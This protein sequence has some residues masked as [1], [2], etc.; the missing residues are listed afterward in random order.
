MNDEDHHQYLDDFCSTF[1]QAVVRLIDQAGEEKVEFNYQGS[2]AEMK[3]I[4]D[5]YIETLEH[6]HQCQ[7]K[8][9]RFYGR[10]DILNCIENYI[11]SDS[12]QPYVVHGE[13]GCGKT[14]V[15][16][17]AAMLVSCMYILTA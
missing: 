4:T 3:L 12:R 16:A 6:A 9:A 15:L 1:E 10:E 2:S 13:S 17:K 8:V 7:T 14:S 5:V 11:S